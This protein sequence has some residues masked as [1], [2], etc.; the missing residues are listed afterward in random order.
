LF[1]SGKIIITIIIIII[2]KLKLKT[3]MRYL[4]VYY[5]N[6][7]YEIVVKLCLAIIIIS[8]CTDCT[9]QYLSIEYIDYLAMNNYNTI[10]N[11]YAQTTRNIF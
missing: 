10:Y 5:Y 2:K 9:L 6:K 1:Y 3:N 4:N 7:M 11:Q 8:H